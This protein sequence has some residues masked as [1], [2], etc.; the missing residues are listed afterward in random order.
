MQEYLEETYG[1]TVYQEQVMLLAQKLA[2]LSKGQADTLRKAMGKKIQEKMDEL[3]PKFIQGCQDNGYD[4]QTA[5]RIWNDWESFASYAFN[6]SHSTCYSFIAFQTGFLK[7]NYPAEYMA[8]VLTHNMQDIKKVSFFMEECKR[9]NIPVLGPDINE[10]RFDFVVNDDDAI[11]FGLGALKGVGQAAVESIV[12]ER[13]ANGPYTSVFDVL[14]R[15]D[16]RSVNKKAFESLALA[17]AF[18]S[19]GP[20][21]RAQ[22]FVQEGSDGQ[23]FLDKLFRYGNQYQ[24]NKN[25]PQATLFGEGDSSFDLPEPDLPKVEEWGT[26]EKLSKEKEVVGVYISGHPLDDHKTVIHH[27]CNADL[28]M[29]KEIPDEHKGKE[30]RVAGIVTQV[31]HKTSKKGHPFG[32]LTVEDYKDSH[33]FFL[34][35]DTYMNNKGLME[36]GT[37]LLITGK[38]FPNKRNDNALELKVDSLSLLAEALDRSAKELTLELPLDELSDDLMEVIEKTFEEQAEEGDCQV[39]FRVK[40]PVEQLRVEMPSKR[41]KVRLTPDLIRE[42]EGIEQV[43]YSLS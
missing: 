28:S 41:M 26:M 1:I 21:N 33:E 4:E 29:L 37:A 39:R 34:F 10:S 9:M 19:V 12:E 14:R 8:S 7:A 24:E 38:P 16:L 11:R 32:I 20:L 31:A 36:E 3:R 23:P 43:S 15:V 30:Y 13:E 35:S 25:A 22:F 6:K 18:D 40:D 27:F 2:G 17:G 5:V 42:L